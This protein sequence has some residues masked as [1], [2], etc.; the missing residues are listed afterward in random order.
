MVPHLVAIGIFL[1]VAIVYCH[2]ALQGKV[3]QQSDVIFWK[4]MAQNS[5][6][7]NLQYGH[8]PLWTTHLFSGMP[9]YQIAMDINSFLPNLHHVLTLWLSKPIDFFF[10]ACISF[11][12]LSCVS[13]ARPVLGIL[14]GLAFAYA[15]F[16][17]LF[18]ATGHDTKMWTLSYMPGLLAGLMLIYKQRYLAGL[19]VTAIFAT[20]EI[21]FNHPQV[22]YYFFFTALFISVG[23][24]IQWIKKKQW[25]HLVISFILAVLG[26]AIGIANSAVTLLTN[27]DY[28]KYTMRGGKTIETKGE[29][30]KE[31][32]TTGLDRDYAFSYS[33][34]KSE[35]LTLFM[36][37]VFGEGTGNHFDE[38]SKLVKNLMEKNV[39][40]SQAIQIAQ[41]MPKYWG[42][43]PEG[44]GGTIYLGAIICFLALIGMVVIQDRIKWWILAGAILAI[45]MAWGRNFSGFNTFL[46]DHLP[47]YNKFRS[48]N[49][50]L[51]I[52]QMIFSL[53]AIMGLQ[54]I[55]FTPDGLEILK[56]SLKK[57]F[58][59]FGALFALVLIIY[60]FNDFT[61]AFD[62]VLMQAFGA[63]QDGN[64][65][66]GRMVVNAMK[67][68]RK[69]MF[70]G[71]I[72]RAFL[73]AALVL[74]L[75][76]LYLK[77]KMK[78]VTAVIILIVVNTFDLL[79]VDNKYLNADNYLDD[80]SALVADYFTPTPADKQILEDKDPHYRVYNIS[81]G[82]PFQ[83]SAAI[84]S[85]FHRN[86]GGYHPAKLRIYQ[87]LIEAQLSKRT[88]NMDVLSMLDTRYIIT[89]PQQ[90][91]QPAGVFKNEEALGAAWFI[92]HIKY[93]NDPVEEIKALDKFGPRDTVIVQNSYKTIVGN[94]PVPDSSATITLVNYNNDE[95]KYETHAATAQFAV[96]SEVYY[97]AGW[98]AYI[99]GKKTDYAKVN[100]VLR[101]IQVPEGKHEV[102]FKFE[103][104]SYSLGQKFVY[105]GNVLF[106]LAMAGGL[107]SIWKW[108]RKDELS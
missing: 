97:P 12:L 24:L 22:T 99:D 96:F 8:F 27:A 79:L 93:V 85:Y 105:I 87:D 69:A 104:A 91:Q 101:G 37:G 18:V 60:F 92:K 72:F 84:T 10:L 39:P 45:F 3:L 78:A 38:N 56:S 31:V 57:I 75:L 49:T 77:N 50:A 33:I 35:T 89:P 28:A 66:V 51:I 83:G 76:L 30:I 94:D 102:V 16:N 62:P 11:Y 98:N 54:Q 17:V 14:G 48:P 23:Y 52:P 64:N 32:S 55:F 67:D 71:N 20:Y 58:Y 63:S 36:P 1:V 25:K 46:L 103:P 90:Q 42:A 6:E 68:D 41:N 70:T 65:E 106:L 88:P 5:I 15:S 100:Y 61:G 59:S 107:F 80:E 53:L 4:G 34:G 82:D 7:Y 81:A 44:T 43:M 21:G 13:G 47:L 29:D 74:G 2:P 73:F 95:I 40:E 86:I 26:G 19:A 9:A 108:W